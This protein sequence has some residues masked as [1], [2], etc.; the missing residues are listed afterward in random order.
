MLRRM[1]QDLRA[2]VER[3]PAATTE[4]EVALLYPGVHALW[5]HRTSRWL[6]LHHARFPARAVS[7]AARWATGIEIHPAARIGERLFIDHGAA[8][9]I[10]ETAEIGDDVTIYHGVTLGGT[11]LDPGKRHPTI[12]DR[13]VIGAGAKVLGNLTVGDDSRIGANAVLLRSVD[14]HSVVVG[15]P[16]QIIASRGKDVTT[17]TKDPDPVHAVLESLLVRV[18]ELEEQVSGRA[19]PAALYVNA[20]GDWEAPDYAI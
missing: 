14:E 10:G 6:W 11:T 3:D 12:G 20:A 19:R 9:V 1:R 18:A 4:W 8:V 17:P 15:V 7:Q 5:A 16:G 13:V 2:V